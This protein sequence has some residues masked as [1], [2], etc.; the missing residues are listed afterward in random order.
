MVRQIDSQAGIRVDR[1]AT[2]AVLGGSLQAD[3]LPNSF[4]QRHAAAAVMGDDIARRGDI[5]S[6]NRGANHVVERVEGE[7]DAI[8]SVAQRTDA[9]LID[10]D[11]IALNDL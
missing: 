11:I 5:G 4:R 3:T 9:R 2:D 10:A 7:E 1:I 8:T 6:A